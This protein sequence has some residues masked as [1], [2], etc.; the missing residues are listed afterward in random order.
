MVEGAWVQGRRWSGL[1][2]RGRTD[3]GTV[4]SGRS[5]T[6]RQPVQLPS[7]PPRR[8]AGPD[9]TASDAGKTRHR[10]REPTEARHRS[11]WAA[12]RQ[13]RQRAKNA[14]RKQE[15]EVEVG[16]DAVAAE[17]TKQKRSESAVAGEK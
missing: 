8:Q 4:I 2:R 11:P 6:L 3:G 1:G 14:T 9:W 5:P 15:V 7:S 12:G 10:S 13:R 16:T 17:S